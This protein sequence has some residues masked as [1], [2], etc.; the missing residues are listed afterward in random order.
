MNPED[1]RDY[2]SIDA[3]VCEYARAVERVGLWESEKQMAQCYFKPSDKIL[4]LGCGCGRISFGLWQLG[5]KNL[6][7]TDFSPAMVAMAQSINET[8]KTEVKFDVQDATALNYASSTFDAAIFG[9]NGIMQIPTRSRRK[10]AMREICRVLKPGGVFVFTTHDR[11]E[12]SSPAYWK[13]ESMLWAENRRNPKLDEFGDICY[14]SEH[15]EIFIHSPLGTV[16][17]DDMHSAGF[18]LI[19][20]KKR[21]EIA[22]ERQAV[23]DF[24]DE[25]MFRVYKKNETD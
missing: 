2:F 7:A 18:E 3:V 4:E 5:Y 25:C 23:K 24:S 17:R 11:E 20:E 21:S 13:H 6:T 9:F 12:T 19:L 10:A 22:F 16:I 8:H 15:G 14:R 1:V